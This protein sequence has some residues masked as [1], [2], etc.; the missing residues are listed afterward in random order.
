MPE[1]PTTE[2]AVPLGTANGESES[3]STSA[4]TGRNVSADEFF[5]PE[6][7]KTRNVSAQEFFGDGEVALYQPQNEDEKLGFL[8]R[9]GED[10]KKR[11]VM[12]GEII[13]ASMNDEQSTAEGILQVAGKVGAGTVLDFLGEVVVSAG[14]GLSAITPDVIEEPIKAGAVSVGHMLL[15]TDIGQ[16][17]LTAAREGVN[18]WFDFK[19]EN[20]RAARNI[21]A[22]VDIGLLV[23]PAR[24]KPKIK[25]GPTPIGKAGEALETKALAQV[26]AKRENFVNDLVQPKQTA[27]VRTEQVARTEEAGLLR[28]KQVTPSA[29]EK[30]MTAEVSKIP[31][32]SK[33]KTLQGNHNIIAKEVTKEADSLKMALM[34][35]D[36]PFPKR[37][38]NA[39]LNDALKRLQD[40]PLIV[41]D[42][43][44][45]ASR[46]VEK[47]RKITNDKKSTASAL[48]EARKELDSWIRSQKGTN[49]FDPKQE[50]ALSIAVREIRNTTNDFIEAKAANVGVKAS[51][52]KQS[53]LLRAMD[54]IAPKAAEE[55]GN[56]FLRLWQNASRLLPLKNE[57]TQSMALIAGVGGLG[58]A[59]M[60]APFFRQLAVIGIGTY[61]TGRLLMSPMT[62]KGIAMLLNTTDRAIR[63]TKDQ[64]LISQMRADR[65][66]ILEL[67]EVA[68]QNLQSE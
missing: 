49:I 21:E 9:F 66:L 35:N 47:M 15:N 16:A 14:R 27:P 20:P 56:A 40:N 39:R 55:A 5:G 58:A 48:L 34:K 11:E 8:K 64:A 46:I 42:A 60:F 62:K 19:K 41:G 25:A 1:L 51:L 52:K 38:F 32:V 59:A 68:D 30:K 13:S 2:T 6:L 22:V 57:F 61:A 31:E 53:T 18:E 43:E 33:S 54:N 17:G 36:V 37:E 45:T 65:A 10:L 63:A 28:S 50:N 3:I 23:A 24:A 44:K 67:S 26:A 7:K 12:Y 4:P 29:A